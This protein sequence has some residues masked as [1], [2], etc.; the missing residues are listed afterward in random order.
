MPTDKCSS[1][2]SPNQ[3]FVID[4][5]FI[6]I[7]NQSKFREQFELIMGYPAP[8]GASTNVLYRPKL[9]ETS[10]MGDQKI[11]RAR[12]LRMLYEIVL[13]KILIGKKHS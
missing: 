6:E 9:Q 3:L 11:V 12:R 4:E 8:N 5:T 10:Q 7:L 1:H 13:F 2:P